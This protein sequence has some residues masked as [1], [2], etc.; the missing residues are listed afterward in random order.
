M[1]LSCKLTNM[2]LVFL[3]L[4]FNKK[5]IEWKTKWKIDMCDIIPFI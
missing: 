2:D 1:S 3:L 4:F 5:I